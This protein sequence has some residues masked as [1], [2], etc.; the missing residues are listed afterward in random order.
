MHLS[1]LFFLLLCLAFFSCKIDKTEAQKTHH[2]FTNELINQSSP[3][4]LQ[5]A[6]NP[7]NWYPWGQKALEKAK[8]ENKMLI[9]SV[10]YA[11]CHWCHVME[12]ESFEDTTVAN[13]M[14]Q[15][16]VAIKVDREERPD[17]DDVYMSACQLASKEGCG[18]PL[19]AFALPD[20][21]PVWAG[22]YFPKKPWLEVLEY[23]KN[24]WQ[25][26]PQKME[27]YATKLTEGVGQ[28]ETIPVRSEV[29]EFSRTSLDKIAEHFLQRIDFQRG[30]RVGAP[31]FPMP[32]NYEFL[33][34]Y[35]HFTGNPRAL[36][37]V[38]LTLDEMANGGIFDH[39]GGGFA[40][41]STDEQ[42]LVPHFE[43][44][45]Y[46]NAQLVSLYSQAFQVSRN[47]AYA[48]VV[49]ETLEFIG[50]EMTSR[51]GAFYSSLDADSEG[52]EGKFYVWQKEEIDSILGS[53]A[54]V[55]CDFFEITQKGN[56]EN[57]KNILYRRKETGAVAKKY[58][59]APD[60]LN[61]LIASEKAKLFKA[62]SQRI[63]PALD[64]KTLTG[65]NALMLK[66]Y[67]DAYRAFGKKSYLDAAL[68]NGHFILEKMLRP[69][70]GLNRNFKD[71][72]SVINA[73]LD[74]YA[75][76]IDA[77]T[78]L[79]QVTF[80]EA[81]LYRAKGLTEY[82]LQHFS[83]ENSSLIFYTSDL[84]PPLIARKMETSDNVIPG[85]NSVMAANLHLLGLYFYKNE[86]M[87]KSR[88]MMHTL[89][90]SVVE[91]EQPDFYSNW[92]QLYLDFVRP[93]YEVAIVGDD[94]AVKR[95]EI[96][97]KFLPNAI[98]LGG[99][100][101]GTLELLKDKLQEGRTMIYVCQNKV[102]KLPVEEVSKAMELME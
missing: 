3:Y 95:D 71:G 72:S 68:K 77:F 37:A 23:F 88:Q 35:H 16:F 73:F 59:L 76:T 56:W 2:Q 41:Y 32:S 20:G 25:K 54:A 13:F 81:W 14:N 6:H 97:K 18:W 21:R 93:P 87:E 83:D 55:F 43:K 22:T 99:R 39:L 7:V 52:E 102:C 58:E 85:S 50:R 28:M 64:D 96:L 8:A 94:F 42:W 74:D 30:G 33:L 5:H 45:L 4:L 63:R 9:I 57:G 84:D 26:S 10:G 44:M 51:E 62:R 53:D 47:P 100:D 66:A 46:D 31:K 90:K 92:C 61:T 67:V 79:C 24:E 60:Q 78:A 65:W 48:T 91:S 75:L 98:L 27:E 89:S 17:V 12:H 101:E 11:A 80:D 29:A 38:T 70:G 86:W 69:D 1:R 36:K 34:K 82:V 40:R 19:N 49:E 15:H